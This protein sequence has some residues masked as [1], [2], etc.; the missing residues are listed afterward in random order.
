MTDVLVVDQ[1]FSISCGNQGSIS[2]D[3]NC[4]NNVL[5]EAL[6]GV[7]DLGTKAQQ[8]LKDINAW[9]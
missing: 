8:L 6:H 3:K 1:N 4:N 7:I 9:K 5:F 2:H